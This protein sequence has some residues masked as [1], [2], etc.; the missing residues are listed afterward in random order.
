MHLGEK[1]NVEDGMR[2]KERE[3]VFEMYYMRKETISVI[4][5]PTKKFSKQNEKCTPIQ[6]EAQTQTQTLAC[7]HAHNHT[8]HVQTKLEYI[9]CWP[10][11]PGQRDLFWSEIDISSE[12][13]TPMEKSTFLYP[14]KY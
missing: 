6:R 13:N 14:N 4:E 2:S 5:I 8:F 7:T 10:T 3:I 9:L 12:D 1:A 11:T